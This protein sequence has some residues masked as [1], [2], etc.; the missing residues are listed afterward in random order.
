VKLRDLAKWLQ[1]CVCHRLPLKII[2]FVLAV[3]LFFAANAER[4][5]QRESETISR[6]I[7]VDLVSIN[8][9]QGYAPLNMPKRVEV[10][11]QTPIG[12]T[13]P[14]ELK[15]SVNLHGRKTGEY[16]IPVHANLPKGWK[17]LEV[18]PQVVSIKIEPIESRSFIATLIVPEGGR[19][20]SPIPLQCNVQ[21]PS[22]TVKQVRAVTGFVNNENAGPA[23]VRLIPV[24]RDGLPVPGAAVFPEWV[25]ID[26]FGAQ[27]SSL[28]Q[29]E[30]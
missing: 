5:A 8:Q 27:E 2:A 17:L 7:L 15:A 29:A 16:T 11:A 22:S 13:I 23:D 21:G 30:D 10:L 24:D 20:E 26:T 4:E 19:M 1:K 9:E 25:R 6:A 18:R 14:A 28:E 12:A 3:L